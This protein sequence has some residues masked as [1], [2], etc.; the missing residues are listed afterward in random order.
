MTHVPGALLAEKFGGKH[1]LGLAM[2]STTILTLLVPF[3]IEI[4]DWI[5]LVVLRILMGLGQGIV[6]PALTVLTAHWAPASEV[7]SMTAVIFVGIDLGIIVGSLL[8]GLILEYSS[9]GWPM[10]FYV[11]SSFGI[12]WYILWLALVYSYPHKHAFISTSELKYLESSMAS[13]K[14]KKL[15]PF[16]WKHVM[17][18]KPFWALMAA[19]IGNDW[20]LYTLLNDLPKYMS[21]VLKLRPEL[22]GYFTAL[23]HF[24][25]SFYVLIVSWV[26]DKSISANHVSKTN[27]RKINTSI[28]TIG[29]ATFLILASYVGCERGLVVFCFVIGV[30]L[31]NSSLIGIKVNSL[32]LSPNYAGTITALTNGVASLTGLGT[33][34]IIGHIV[35]HDT[36]TEWQ[37]VFWLAAVIFFITNTIFLFYASGEIQEWNDPDAMKKRKEKTISNNE[38]NSDVKEKVDIK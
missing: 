20:G 11:F 33:S 7:S 25:A 22:N 14:L 29:P 13:Y 30:T 8:S 21:S 16:P 37:T 10:I 4:G 31:M 12:I 19:Q 23:P 15:P 6:F 2:L 36:R 3:A 1:T 38:L 34:S 26:T 32:D 24:V 27:A 9:Y 5:A 28:S 17:K 35:D 18:S